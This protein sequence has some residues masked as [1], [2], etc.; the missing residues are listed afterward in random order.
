MVEVTALLD[1]DGGQGERPEVA[2]GSGYKIKEH[3][4]QFF[5]LCSDCQQP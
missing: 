5:G 2:R 3:W 4:L 1:D